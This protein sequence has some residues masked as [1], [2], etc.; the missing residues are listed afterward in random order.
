M[1]NKIGILN[2][3]IAGNIHSVKKAIIRSGGDAQVINSPKEIRRVRS[4]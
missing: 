3:G 4:I 1:K 2:F